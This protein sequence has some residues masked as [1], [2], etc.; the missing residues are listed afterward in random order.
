[1][2]TL[3]ENESGYKWGKKWYNHYKFPLIPVLQ[4][5]KANSHNTSWFAF[6]WLIIRIWSRDAF[7]FEIAF[8]ASTHWGIGITMLLPYLRLAFCLPCPE[9]LGMWIDKYTSRSRHLDYKNY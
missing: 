2:E 6:D 8:T 3:K 5:R 1:M 4:T 9:K 7:D